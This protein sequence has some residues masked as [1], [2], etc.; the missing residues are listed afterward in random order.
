MRAQQFYIAVILRQA[1]YGLFLGF[2]F[3]LPEIKELQRQVIGKTAGRP[4]GQQVVLHHHNFFHVHPV[5]KGANYQK[6][7]VKADQWGV[8]LLDRG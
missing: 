7:F 2:M 3:L 8:G 6:L 5:K 1:P 4:R